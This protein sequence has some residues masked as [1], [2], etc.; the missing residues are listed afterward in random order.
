MISSDLKSHDQAVRASAK[1][2]R[3]L[4]LLRSTFVSRCTSI[5]LKL[6]TT[7]VRP[8]LEFAVPAWRPHAAG[9][10]DVIERVQ[11]RATRLMHEIRGLD[12]PDRCKHLGIEQLMDRRERGDLIQMY[13]L[14]HGL[15]KVKWQAP[16]Q[17]RPPRGG[18][19]SMLAREI[20]KRCDARHHFFT[21][22]SANIWNQ[23]PD[24]VVSAPTINSFKSKLDKF[25]QGC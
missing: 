4:G 7:Y 2:M 22:R 17:W 13:K 8:H 11:R 23:L 3:M 16:L 20:F 15:D 6:Y 25:R 14:V 18:N 19:R 5:R 12:Y 21:N 10:I 9:D 24:N 1:A